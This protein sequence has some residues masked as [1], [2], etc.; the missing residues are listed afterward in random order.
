MSY[1]LLG[2]WYAMLNRVSGVF[3]IINET[4]SSLVHTNSSPNLQLPWW[5][6][7]D[8]PPSSEIYFVYN[9]H[10]CP[11]LKLIS[12]SKL[13]LSLNDPNLVWGHRSPSQ[14]CEMRRCILDKMIFW[15]VVLLYSWRA[16]KG[17]IC[18]I[19]GSKRLLLLLNWIFQVSLRLLQ[20][21]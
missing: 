1:S 5:S 3:G 21:V 19:L 17:A 7:S 6:V 11:T 2:T 15:S 16:N 14:A 20:E 12:I 8:N 4:H 10:F 18:F 9:S 13:I